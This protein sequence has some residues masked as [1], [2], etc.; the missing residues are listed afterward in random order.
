MLVADNLMR[1]AKKLAKETNAVRLRASTSRDNDVA[2]KTYESIGFRE[3]QEFKS[4]ILPISS[5]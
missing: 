3:D 5:D 2:M 1:A 4:Y